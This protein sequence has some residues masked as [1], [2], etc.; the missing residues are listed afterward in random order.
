MAGLTAGPISISSNAVISSV[1]IQPDGKLLL[2][3]AF[4]RVNG[5]PRNT[6]VR[7]QPDGRVDESFGADL[8]IDK[9]V[10][11]LAIQPDGHIVLGDFFEH[12]NGERRPFIARLQPDGGVDTSFQPNGGPTSDWVV[13]IRTL[14]LQADGTLYL[15]GPF[16]HVNSLSAPCLVRLNLGPL[17]AALHDSALTANQLAATVHGLPGGVYPVEASADLE[18]WESA[19]EVWLEGYDTQAQFT[20]PALEGLRFFR[21][22]PHG[23]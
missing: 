16:Q 4:S 21:L 20:T 9:A 2:V 13:M 5:Q 23:Q 1:E 15:S 10:F 17:V 18:H 22:K 6:L 12:I 14:A 7:L 8:H 11:S 3:G 19:G